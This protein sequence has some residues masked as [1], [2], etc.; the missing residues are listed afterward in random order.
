MSERVI[1][2]PQINL[3]SI[4]THY[5]YSIPTPIPLPLHS[6]S[7]W[8]SKTETWPCPN[9]HPHLTRCPFPP[10]SLP[11]APASSW[12]FRPDLLVGCSLSL[13]CSSPFLSLLQFILHS[14]DNRA[15]KTNT[16]PVASQPSLNLFHGPCYPGISD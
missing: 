3:S 2:C 5:G 13:E 6:I 7:S 8:L 14:A 9:P 4:F 1:K 11:P 16:N 10:C 15:L 12:N